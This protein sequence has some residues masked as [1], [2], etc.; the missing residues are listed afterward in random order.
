MDST[1]LFEPG[2]EKAKDKAMLMSGEWYRQG[3]AAKPLYLSYPWQ[4][5]FELTVFGRRIPW[6]YHGLSV[7]FEKDT[8]TIFLSKKTLRDAAAF[9][10]SRIVSEPD[11]LPHLFDR[12]LSVNVQP[13]TNACARLE[14]TDL[15]VLTN[16]KVL[17]EWLSF[18]DIYLSLWRE[19]IFLDSFDVWGSEMLVSECTARGITLSQ[20]ELQLLTTP[21]TP[22][23]IQK[24]DMELFSIFE[25]FVFGTPLEKIMR[26]GTSRTYLEGHYPDVARAM[27]AYAKTYS[28]SMNDYA[29]IR[30][31]SLDDV[32]KSMKEMLEHDGIRTSHATI[33]AHLSEIEQKKKECIAQHCLASDAQKLFESFTLLSVIRDHR[34]AYNQMGNSVIHR[35]A[36]EAS[37]RSG[38]S[39]DRIERLFCTE[40]RHVFALTANDS[41][42]LKKRIEKV[43]FFSPGALQR[44]GYY[45]KDAQELYDAANATIVASATLQGMS[46]Y[47]GVVRGTA[48]LILKQDD[49]P[50][51]QPGDI[52]VAPN[53]RPE[54]MPVMRKAAAIVTEEGGITCHA[55]IVSRELKI[56]CI[57]GVQSA[58]SVLHDGDRVE[59]DAVSGVVRKTAS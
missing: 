20:E 50:K 42:L 58:T 3:A 56:P 52:L 7:F 23:W 35:F 12:W 16:E 49:F 54:Y 45:A 43:F 27:T 41:A 33:A 53:T 18:A 44:V 15:S 25:R 30:S 22:S 9:Y 28:W 29:T 6:V 38:I 2:R 1:G 17:A 14:E 26:S 34:K 36:S 39:L 4:T 5:C 48:R 13:F 40:V 32:M 46:A 57:V 11:F 21:H 37:R 31:L 47:P 55:A 24:K 59:V 8:C 19:A 51:M 10:W